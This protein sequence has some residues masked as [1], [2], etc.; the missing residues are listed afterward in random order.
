MKKVLVIVGPTSV[1]KS[2]L[3]IRIASLL[4][5]EIISGD[6]IQVYRQLTIGS[7]KITDDEMKGVT[8]HCI[9]SLDYNE[10]YS[11]YDFQTQARTA[12]DKITSIGKLP[13]IVGGTGFYIKAALYDYTFETEEEIVIDEL[14]EE[15]S[16][17][18]YQKLNEI[19]PQA[20]L[21]IHPNNRKRLIRALTI[22]S[23]GKL[24]SE[25]ENEQT[26]QPLYDIYMVVLDVNRDILHQRIEQRVDRMFANGLLEEVNTYFGDPKSWVYQSFQGIG[27]KEWMPYLQGKQSIQEVR[28]AIIVHTR[29]FAKRQYTW[30]RHQFKANW[31][32]SS[33]EKAI[34]T[35]LEEIKD[36]SN[37]PKGEL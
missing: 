6:S 29:Q 13:I 28:Q 36:W 4:P 35:V 31:V 1:G 23:H 19:D 26:H 15:T 33:D 16:E 37:Q 21:K 18:L 14:T 30:F 20:A 27:Y 17:E 9:D 8:H 34:N 7:A 11:V 5:S 24:K 2:D 10:S 12:I 32:D 25:I 3:S 22:A